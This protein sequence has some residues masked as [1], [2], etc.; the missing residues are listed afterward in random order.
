MTQ[1]EYKYDPNIDPA[2]AKDAFIYEE[3]PST[4]AEMTWDG[5]SR[6]PEATS[7]TEGGEVRSG[8]VLPA[9]LQ[10]TLYDYEPSAGYRIVHQPYYINTAPIEH[11]LCGTL[12]Y[13]AQFDGSEVNEKTSLPMTYYEGELTFEV[14]SEDFALAGGHKISLEAFLTKYPTNR[15]PFEATAIEFLD[16]CLDPTLHG[17]PL[18]D[19]EYTITDTMKKYQIPMF[20]VEPIFCDITYQMQVLNED[21][22]KIASFDSH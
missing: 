19:Q 8:S 11:E 13:H 2:D 4:L 20:T 7:T 22:L 18:D 15:G 9:G 16:P 14:Y 1:E 10:Y 6:T 5:A 3:A 21:V 17:V 12:S